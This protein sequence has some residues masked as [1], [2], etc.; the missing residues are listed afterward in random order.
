MRHW[1]CGAVMCRTFMGV[2][3]DQWKNGTAAVGTHARGDLSRH[4][5]QSACSLKHLLLPA[6]MTNAIYSTSELS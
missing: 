3:G 6:L 5:I 4:I 1:C 2:S